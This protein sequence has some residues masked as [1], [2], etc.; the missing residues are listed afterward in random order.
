MSAP[1]LG[2]NTSAK[3]TSFA[4]EQFMPQ[5]AEAVSRSAELPMG[6]MLYRPPNGQSAESFFAEVR[7]RK[8][9]VP[10]DLT[11][12]ERAV[13]EKHRHAERTSINVNIETINSGHF[14]PLLDRLDMNPD[15][16]CIE[17]TEQGGVPADFDHRK[18]ETLKKMGFGLS[19]DDVDI[20]DAR[21][22]DRMGKLGPFVDTIKFPHQIAAIFRDGDE[23]DI[24]TISTYI[25]AAK[26]LYPNALQ[27]MEGV[28]STDDHLAPAFHAAGID[29]FQHSSYL[30]ASRASQPLQG[31]ILENL[32][33]TGLRQL[34]IAS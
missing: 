32:R 10:T 34:A 8:M 12:F 18:L 24:E 3:G 27:I 20:L 29:I 30:P 23:S 17:V 15:T 4:F 26:A 25:R 19:L 13:A 7:K 11:I 22:W 31:R 28:R 21:E 16:I 2:F 6:E 5:S 33:M 1:I 9:V 14:L